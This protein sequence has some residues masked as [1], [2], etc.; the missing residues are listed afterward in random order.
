[1]SLRGVVWIGILAGNLVFWFVVLNLVASLIL[2]LVA[3]PRG[4][5]GSAPPAFPGAS[6]ASGKRPS[7]SVAGLSG[8]ALTS[9]AGEPRARRRPSTGGSW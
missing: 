1:M 4:G 6:T 8:G 3:T 7:G 2:G 5:S 9:A